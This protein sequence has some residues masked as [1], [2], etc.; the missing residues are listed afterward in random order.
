VILDHQ[1]IIGRA[2]E[3][4]RLQKLLEA[5]QS[6]FL[7]VYGRRRIG[8][9]YLIKNFFKGKGLFFHLAGIQGSSLEV[10]LQNF[11]EEFS[12]LFSKGKKIKMPKTWFSAFQMLRKELVRVSKKTKIIL[13]FDELP[14][15]ATPRS[16]FL[17]ALE[18]LWNRYLSDMP[19]LILIVCGSAASWML[20]HVIFHRGGLHGR[21]THEMR[22]LPF[23]L[24]ETEEFLHHKGIYLDRRQTIELYM[25]LG[26]VASY[27]SYLEK[28]KSVGQL[29]GELCFSYNGPLIAEFHKLYRSLFHNYEEHEKIV[30][31]LAET[32]SGLSYQALAQK[33]K[34]RVGGTFSKRLEELKQ[35][36]FII[37]V[38]LFGEE[39]K[40]SHFLLVD[41][42]SH[43]YLKW[44]AGVSALD[45]QSKGVDYWL[46]KQNTQTWKTWSGHAF[47]MLC[48]KHV[49]GI[50]AALGIG[51][52]QTQ[53]SKWG[54]SPSRGSHEVGAQIDLVVDRADHCINLCEI[55][56]YQDECIIDKEYAQKL[57]RKKAC[58]A[59]M[60]KT[61]KALF[62]TLVTTQGVKRNHHFLASVDQEVG[63]NA[64][65]F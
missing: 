48:L 4:E 6:T 62:T 56:Y 61:Q 24:R 32:R 58:F 42:Y 30:T 43:F 55:K 39:G 1:V 16:N 49:D 59:R 64:L 50:K 41:E 31:A 45:L 40:Q 63:L 11:V 57:Q 14:W 13:F 8:K 38:P 12:D 34:K 25:C 26:G 2:K 27:L 36:G 18:H 51:A 54:Y 33:L 9:T 37:E 60:T 5:N 19:N 3:Q 53:T 29:I 35:S 47:E 7:A 52:V 28:G 46:K 17:Q 20:D 22:L 15:L 23:T 10:Q 65:F 44:H 21:V